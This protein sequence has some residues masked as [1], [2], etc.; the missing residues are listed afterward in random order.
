MSSF[1]RNFGGGEAQNYDFEYV[2]GTL[3]VT[4]FS[5]IEALL[6]SGKPFDVYTTSGVKV[7][8][9]VTTLKGLPR[10]VYI[11][12]NMKVFVI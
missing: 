1:I 2:G 11:I 6:V 5:G 7:K 9:Q 12:N 10:G 3:T 4:M 8:S